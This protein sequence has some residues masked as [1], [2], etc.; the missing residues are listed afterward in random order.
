[1]D[2]PARRAFQASITPQIVVDALGRV[3]ELNRAAER[4]LDVRAGPAR[5]TALAHVAPALN[6]FASV[7]PRAGPFEL[8]E[9]GTDRILSVDVRRLPRRGGLVLEVRDVTDAVHERERSSRRAA[10]FAAAATLGRAVDEED[11]RAEMDRALAGVGT[12]LDL[13]SAELIQDDGTGEAFERHAAWLPDGDRPDRDGRHAYVD[14]GLGSV[15]DAIRRGHATLVAVPRAGRVRT[16][17]PV[18]GPDGAWAALVLDGAEPDWLRELREPLEE[19]ARGMAAWL[20]RRR[21]EAERRRDEVARA[22]L[23]ELTSGL[24]R[25]DVADPWRRVLRATIRAT[26]DVPGGALFLAGDDGR[27]RCVA[28]LGATP[29]PAAGE[30]RGAEALGVRPDE[31]VRLLLGGETG[32]RCGAS[33]LATVTNDGRPVGALRLD[34]PRGADAL[35]AREAA[36]LDAFADHL[37]PVLERV[38]LQLRGERAARAQRRLAKIERL[39]LSTEGVEAFFPLLAGLLIESELLPLHRVGLLQLAEDGP[40]LTLHG[41]GGR[42]PELERACVHSGL[43]E[44]EQ[45]LLQR[46]A[47]GP[48]PSIRTDLRGDPAWGPFLPYARAAA[49][50]PLRQAGAP[51]GAVVCTA[52]DPEGFDAEALA[53][54][55]QLTSALE[56]ALLR[57]RD[58]EARERQLANLRSLVTMGEALQG[59][60]DRREVVERTLRTLLATT[61]A[62]RATVRVLDEAGTRLHALGALGTA[63]ADGED[64]DPAWA[65]VRAEAGERRTAADGPGGRAWAGAPVRNGEGRVVGAVELV[66]PEGMARFTDADVSVLEAAAQAAGGAMVR[67]ALLTQSRRQAED[68]RVLWEEARR[69]EQRFRML[70]EN[71]GD[72][73]GLHAP[74]GRFLYASPA[75]RAAFGR[76][77]EDLIGSRPQDLAAPE[78][79]A[80]AAEVWTTPPDDG[81][82]QASYRVPTGDDVIVWLETRVRAVRDEAGA[83][84]NLV[85]TTRDVTERKRLEERLVHGAL[86]DDL[87][88]LPNRA[89]LRDRMGHALERMRRAESRFALLFLDLDGFKEVNDTLGHAVGDDMLAAV[90]RRLGACVRGSDTVAR[91]GGDEFCVLIEAVEEDGMVLRTAERIQAALTQPFPLAGRQL[92]TSASIGVAFSRPDYRDPEEILRDADQAMYRA[93]QE[94]PGRLRVRGQAEPRPPGTALAVAPADGPD[95]LEAELRQAVDRDELRLAFQPIVRV[96][97]GAV[98]G[99]EALVRWEHPTLGLL[100]AAAFV[101]LAERTGLI[102][103]LDRWTLDRA[104]RQLAAW[105]RRYPSASAWALSVNLSSQHFAL[106]DPAAALLAVVR[107]A[108]LEASRL[109]IELAEPTLRQHGQALPRALAAL[110]AQGVSLGVEDVGTGDLSL[111]TLQR[112]EVGWLKLDRTL[113]RELG[114]RPDRLELAAGIGA[115]ARELGVEAVAEGVEHE[116]DRN[117]LG[118]LGYALGQGWFWSAALSAAELAERYLTAPSDGGGSGAGDA[119][120]C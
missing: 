43:L 34:D 90:A 113:A 58:R 69:G 87:T 112:L 20:E 89:L 111:T 16:A 79:R 21:R 37:G 73:V 31:P 10:L 70:A 84:V 47:R 88:G 119:E 28:T 13:G 23:Q 118:A 30:R 46:Q 62:A 116:A 12:A 75:A 22:T 72:A 29:A 18:R 39:L 76:P 103:Q 51:W 17:L 41:P 106:P 35:G 82:R 45:D 9:A 99:V 74:D 53:W 52:S 104:C 81:V 44:A 77:A 15:R 33:L 7:D 100:P 57:D 19:V 38:A 86:Y 107:G 26:G 59:A 85:S 68:Y 36:R 92:H 95:G 1:M 54:F 115:L 98:I 101:P 109:R 32:L 61:P 110:R 120:R 83:A 71:V 117:A 66:A 64:D 11:A 67:L 48:T 102:V 55:G 60:V 91:L 65:V 6:R 14:D 2:D 105:S 40:S 93:K 114:D 56:I 94:G 49:V 96:G 63:A 50:F 108:G 97:G 80:V 27:Y 25:N 4:W 24:L 78:D 5:G 8:V 42:D 3:S